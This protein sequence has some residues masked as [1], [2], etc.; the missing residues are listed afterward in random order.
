M[1]IQYNTNMYLR[2]QVYTT[3]VIN[4]CIITDDFL[5]QT[6]FD[7][8]SLQSFSDLVV[9]DFPVYSTSVVLPPGIDLILNLSKI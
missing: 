7:L 3:R 9:D 1:N 6:F 2:Q 4:I 8:I 5:S